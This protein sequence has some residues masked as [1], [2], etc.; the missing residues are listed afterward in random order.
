MTNKKWIQEKLIE[1][2]L[3]Q[4]QLSEKIG[5]DPGAM[6]RTIVGRRRLQIDE[7]TAIALIFNCSL[8]EVLINFGISDT[9]PLLVETLPI[10]AEIKSGGVL[11]P[12]DKSD[13]VPALP[14]IPHAKYVAQWRDDASVFDGW[15]FYLSDTT[16]IEIDHMAALKLTD[17]TWALGVASR[18]YTAGQFQISL[19]GGGKF[20]SGITEMRRVL[21]I[22]P[23]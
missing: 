19:Q 9:S 16:N 15:L 10:I 20:Q 4:R 2:E 13:S 23:V 7:A 6:S 17:G 8:S 3:S 14:S 1:C 12:L 11:T 5:L 21:A 18:S 22:I